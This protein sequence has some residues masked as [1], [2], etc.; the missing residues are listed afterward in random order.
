MTRIPQSSLVRSLAR[1]LA[2]VLACLCVPAF[3]DEGPASTSGTARISQETPVQV[4]GD[5]V[6]YF[7]EEQRVV[8]TGNVRIDHEGVQLT[9]DKISVNLATKMAVAEGHVT[10]TQT[11]S[12]FRG[13]RAEYNFQTKV[14]NVSKMAAE[15]QP[16]YYGKAE[17]IEKVS[18]THYRA[19]DSYVTTC[20]GDKPFYRIR[21][22][23]I[24]IHPGEKV[25]IRNAV[26]YIRE[27]P[28]LFLPYYVQYFIDFDRFPVQILPGKNSEWGAFALSKWR[29][30]L[31]DKPELSSKG[32]VLFDWREKRGFGGG[33]ENFY[34]GDRVGRG[35][36]RLY[37]AD[38]EDAPAGV[39][40]DR[41]RAQWRHQSKVTPDTTLTVELNK[42]SDETIV[43]DFFFHEEYERDV[44]PDNYVSL[45]TSKPEYTMSFLLRD[46]LNEFFT[47][48][49]RSPQLRFDTHNRQ[50]ADTPFYV[51]AEYQFD[52]LSKRFAEVSES[53]EAV[54]FDT[55]HTL[56]YRG[57]LDNVSIVPRVGTRQ[58]Y[59]SRD[60]QG[61][62]DL[63][64][65]TFEPGLDVSTKFFK[66]Y[67]VSTDFANLDYN[68]IRHVFT[69]SAAYGWRPNP[70]VARTVLQQFDSLD[71]V[72]KQNLVHVDLENKLQTKQHDSLGKLYARE[73]ARIVP[74][75]DYDFH[76]GRLDNV[77]YDVEL[78]PYR[79][80]GIHSDLLYETR[81]GKVET[82]S[83]DVG[84][85]FG[86]TL[87]VGV[88]QRY[89]REESSQTTA[90][91]RWKINDAWEI[92]LY[93]RYDFQQEDND[94]FEATITKVWDCVI[95]DFTYNHR[96][97]DTFYFVMRL[98][99]FP[100]ASFRLSQSYNRPRTFQQ[101]S[102]NA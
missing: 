21:A 9:A 48:V 74:F 32:N 76:T 7:H 3:A 70:T 19:V 29:Y 91:I 97:G 57:R 50:L 85:E 14:G 36:V 35:A 102:P 22:R 86:N 95:T 5:S 82:A 18:D 53:Q 99:A 4:H 20:C 98:K 12:V 33:V 16:S 66:T 81:T 93:E 43:K 52:N 38:D 30:H 23:E 79:W 10:L 6:E 26:L 67:D 56:L 25:V 84:Y 75:F 28:V 47:V 94:E 89:V 39:D 2:V 60:G 40:N 64:R 61:E 37:Y 88:G 101:V 46:R 27:V 1:A 71:A 42:L 15:I 54:R 24:D 73:I 17:R 78:K 45:I 72:D 13:D 49:E 100:Q 44:F 11:G 31:L 77:G 68:Q 51:R 62:R 59:Y 92:R 83:F 63:V 65:A 34:R 69:P 90:E 8:G 87:R 41:Y 58:T 55:N 80:L 96:D